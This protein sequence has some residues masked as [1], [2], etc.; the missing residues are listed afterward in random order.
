MLKPENYLFALEDGL[1]VRDSQEYALD[2]LHAVRA[3]LTM[4]R[5]A[6]SK[7]P[8][9]AFN[10]IDLQAGP[11]KNRIKNKIYLG[12]PLLSLSIQPPFTNYWFNERDYFSEL[13]AR[14]NASPLAA[15]VSL[16][17]M[18]VNEA[19]DPIVEAIRSMD[20][21]RTQKLP[22]FNIAFLDPEGLEL[23][24]E[25]VEKLAQINRMDLIINF[26]T[27]GINRNLDRPE[28]IDRYFG[29]SRWREMVTSSDPTSRRRQFINLY[30]QQLESFNYHIVTDDDSSGHHDIA[31]RNTKNAE[32]YSLIFA[33]K[34]PLGD[35]FWRKVRQQIE[36]LRHGS[37]PLF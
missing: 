35:D 28:T 8:W 33:S 23:N 7:T 27:V 18:D 10:Y 26:S 14:V 11:G 15:Q 25:T 29:S 1:A 30:R 37:S 22:T 9:T 5:I 34:H 12:S 36:R 32:V 4:A 6:M 3:Y 19:V 31:M 13:Q 20:R 21:T 24:W 16:F 17:Q 2:K